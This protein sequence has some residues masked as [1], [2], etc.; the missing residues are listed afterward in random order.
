M[1][2]RPYILAETTWHA[3]KETTYAVAVLPWGATE[4]HNHHLPYATDTIQNDFI[5]AEAARI[6]WDQGA[7]VIVLPTIPFGVNTGQ[8]DVTLDINMMPSTQAAVLHDVVHALATQG[9]PRLVVMNGHGGNNFKQMIREVGAFF[10]E[11]FIC[12]FNW[13][14]ILDNAGFF[15]E[16]GDHAG[17]METSIMQ[18]VVP[19]LVRPL[20]EAGPGAARRFRVQGLRDG[21]AWAER[22]WLQ[23]T[24]D[25]GIGNPA[26]ATAEKGQCFLTAL[27]GQIAGFL[28]D[29]AACDLDDLYEPEAGSG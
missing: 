16:P 24:D 22:A 23:V 20:A 7:R 18:H 25:T 27:T 19:D 5:A 6:A 4:A 15:D 29:L 3:V 8:L 14:Q 11:V 17:E 13:Y 2:G 10:P 12:T 9:I 1:P 21:W 28:V 26:R